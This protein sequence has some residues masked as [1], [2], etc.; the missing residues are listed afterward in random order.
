MN[1]LKFKGKFTHDF[2]NLILQHG[3]STG[4]NDSD[5]LVDLI[6]H[7]SSNEVKEVI[8]YMPKFDIKV[9]NKTWNEAK[10]KLL[11]LYK[12]SD[13]P[14]KITLEAL[15][16]FC[17]RSSAKLSFIKSIE[18][19]TYQC[20]FI[21][22]TALLVKKSILTMQQDFYFINGLLSSMKEWFMN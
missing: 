12:V 22:L 15:K 8:H 16:D 11:Q 6:Y 17:K 3:K 1:A 19:E 10:A 7:Y 9:P 2:L 13:E 14:A 4:I 5:N 20:E 18:V 21:K